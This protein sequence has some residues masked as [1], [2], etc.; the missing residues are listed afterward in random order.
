MK[1]TIFIDSLLPKD[2]RQLIKDMQLE[3]DKKEQ[4]K[5]IIATVVSNEKKR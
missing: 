2:L 5:S 4:S 1:D 3:L